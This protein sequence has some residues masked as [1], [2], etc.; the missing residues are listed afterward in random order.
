MRFLS[1][2]EV[3]ALSSLPAPLPDLGSP[4]VGFSMT[5]DHAVQLHETLKPLRP[6]R[7]I[8]EYD[9]DCLPIFVRDM[10][11]EEYEAAFAAW[12]ESVEKWKRTNGR[13]TTSGPMRYDIDVDLQNGK[14]VSLVGDGT[15]WKVV[16]SR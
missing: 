16:G 6:T 11:D 2:D 13:V 12:R 5:S 9:D 10:T 15:T 3:T 1:P 8:Y 4:V 14:R 7:S